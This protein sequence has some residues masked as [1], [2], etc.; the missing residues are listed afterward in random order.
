MTMSEME[1]IWREKSDEDLLEAA[2]HLAEFTAE[3]QHVVREELRRR[4]LEDPVEQAREA[5]SEAAPGEPEEGEPEGGTL[6]APDCTRCHI[7]LRYRGTRMLM[8]GDA[9]HLFSDSDA[10]QV[11]VCPQCGHVEL[12][13]SEIGAGGSQD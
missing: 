3:G 13:A 8:G 12:F 2:A 9:G 5:K 1:E 7:E 11:Y 10:F 4:G 6:V